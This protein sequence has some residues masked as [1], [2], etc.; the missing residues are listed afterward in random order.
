MN[1]MDINN[2]SSDFQYRFRH[3]RSCGSQLCLS[4]HDLVSALDTRQQVDMAVLDFNKAFDQ[5][6]HQCLAA[7]LDSY[8]IDG[9]TEEWVCSFLA[10]SHQHVVIDESKS[11]DEQFLSGVPQG[12][13]VGLV[14]F[15]I[16]IHDIAD[17]ITRSISLFADDCIM[18]RAITSDDDHHALQADLD[19][20]HQ[21]S[22]NW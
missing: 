20:L 1:Y 6:S 10:D 13:V 14:L 16:Y 4:V 11:A 5:V 8:S 17:N 9:H 22:L 3:N 12:S 2:L 21:W 7:M 19:K 18:Y 15:L